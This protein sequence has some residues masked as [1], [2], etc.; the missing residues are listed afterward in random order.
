MELNYKKVEDIIV[1]Y[2]N[3]EKVF[4]DF[5]FTRNFMNHIK[6]FKDDD[7]VA[8]AFYRHAIELDSDNRKSCY[9]VANACEVFED[10][11]KGAN[12]IEVVHE[13]D[14]EYGDP[15]SVVVKHIPS[16][17]YMKHECYEGSYGDGY[18]TDFS[19][20][21]QVYPRERIVID[22]VD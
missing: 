3:G 20:W 10:K 6:M 16:G 18:N 4:D 17:L 19:N 21:V 12:F 22:F 11:T 9:E 1:R 7:F 14:G 15:M 2:T 8:E 13:D 5:E